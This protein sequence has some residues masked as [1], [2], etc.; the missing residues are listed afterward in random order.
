MVSIHQE[1]ENHVADLYLGHTFLMLKELH[2]IYVCVQMQHNGN[3]S[4]SSSNSSMAEEQWRNNRW[5]GGR[6]NSMDVATTRRD[7]NNNRVIH[8]G[9]V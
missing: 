5:H 7:G 3:L 6:K 1:L 2:L 9:S 8:R 4:I